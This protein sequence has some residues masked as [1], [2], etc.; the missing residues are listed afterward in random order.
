MKN[1]ND[2]NT[3]VSVNYDGNTLDVNAFDDDSS[4]YMELNNDEL[5]RLLSQP[6]SSMSL[7]NR[8]KKDF[9]IK[10]SPFSKK[11]QHTR[12][13]HCGRRKKRTRRSCYGKHNHHK[14]KTHKKPTIQCKSHLPKQKKR[15]TRKRVKS[16]EKTIY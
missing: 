15:K 5:S 7:E 6:A 16:I 2:I 8:L 11:A 14:P 13:I 10:N 12:R 4:L 1:M 9:H 3:I